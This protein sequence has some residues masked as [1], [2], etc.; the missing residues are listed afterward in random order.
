M[1]NVV[2]SAFI[3]HRVLQDLIYFSMRQPC[4]AQSKSALMNQGQWP[5]LYI[6]VYIIQY[7]RWLEV[8]AGEGDI[9]PLTLGK[10]QCY[11]C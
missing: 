5:V 9:F 2:L 10:A 4:I 1:C 7:R 6:G 11:K 8:T 3:F